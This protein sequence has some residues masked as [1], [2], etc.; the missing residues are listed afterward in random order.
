M[1][2]AAL[3]VAARAEIGSCVRR[4]TRRG[5]RET[6]VMSKVGYSSVPYLFL[7]TFNTICV[8]QVLR[9]GLKGECCLH[10]LG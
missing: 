4:C 2:R 9:N 5:V 3:A 1:R 6:A 7:V 8:S 10:T